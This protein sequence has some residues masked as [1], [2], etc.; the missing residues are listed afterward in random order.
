MFN[1]R[2]ALA[3]L[4]LAVTLTAAGLARADG[5]FHDFE[6]DPFEGPFW[7][8]PLEPTWYTQV[9]DH[10][11]VGN[12]ADADMYFDDAYTAVGNAAGIQG[13]ALWGNV[14]P[15]A[16]TF[17][18]E[19]FFGDDFD[20]G[21][22]TIS[23]DFAWASAGGTAPSGVFVSLWSDQ[24]EDY[25]D[26][27]PL[28]TT[29]DAGA[30]YGNNTGYTHRLSF[31]AA[32]L[33]MTGGINLLEID[34]APLAATGLPGEF[35]ID[36]LAVNMDEGDVPDP[37]ESVVQFVSHPDDLSVVS[38]IGIA[39]LVDTSL[40]ALSHYVANVG[41][42]PTTYSIEITGE[43]YDAFGDQQNLPI[44][45]GETP[46]PGF[47]AHFDPADRL[48]GQYAGQVILTN[49]LNPND[50]PKTLDLGMALFD[51]AS[52]TAN[53]AETLDPDASVHA[54]IANAAP[55]GH[56]GAQRAQARLDSIVADHALELVGLE[57]GDAI[58]P[59][60]A[61]TIAQIAPHTA[62]LLAGTHTG[63]LELTFRM[64]AQNPLLTV[65]PGFNGV[66][67]AWAYQFTVDA[68]ETAQVA[69]NPGQTI[70]E[71]NAEIRSHE[72]AARLRGGSVNTAFNV[73]LSFDDNPEDDGRPRTAHI[74]GR[75]VSLTLDDINDLFALQIAY[76]PNLIP[77]GFD[78][79]DLRLK[80]W[81]DTLGWVH[82]I[83]LN[84]DGGT[85]GEFHASGF[86]DA[87]DGWGGELVLSAFG[88]DVDNHR[89]WAVL[90]H[91]SLFAAGVVPEP[92][93]AGV[94]TVMLGLSLLRRRRVAG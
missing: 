23:F 41:T 32:D 49:D 70:D 8:S 90:D 50:P 53:T 78:E 58:T 89:L 37:A 16:S 67:L 22:Q 83:M 88:V 19:F 71:L 39:R 72:T 45:P 80:V 15:D 86:D 13:G 56:E 25:S 17:E 91:N 40:T 10:I 1:R 18:L 12:W 35:A 26:L 62:G 14:G 9:D 82:A 44:A 21:A 57:V 33:G 73:S 65:G 52:L 66:D 3:L 74:L 64:V 54:S 61:A 46:W 92:A 84:S 85:G 4:T 75:A 68:Q 48:S 36:N 24:G 43:F 69:A 38:G 11:G 77:A 27:F 87:V 34:L 6:S 2:C 94:L 7:V 5:V 47:T 29:F 55:L 63:T 79:L 51:P 30:T 81:D 93:T 42:G 31:D 60:A 76:D 28:A 20:E 59:G